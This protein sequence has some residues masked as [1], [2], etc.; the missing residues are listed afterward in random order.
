[1]NV[2]LPTDKPFE[3]HLWEPFLLNLDDYSFEVRIDILNTFLS[4]FPFTARYWKKLIFLHWQNNDIPQVEELFSTALPKCPDLDL[5]RFHIMFLSRDSDTAPSSEDASD[6]IDFDKMNDDRFER[7]QRGFDN[8]IKVLG[9]DY[10]AFPLYKGY[11]A[12]LD[13]RVYSNAYA[14]EQKLILLR[15]VYRQ[16]LRTPLRGGEELFD[17]Y[18]AF[19]KIQSPLKVNDL[20]NEAK[21]ELQTS[22]TV[23]KDVEAVRIHTDL[24]W[25]SLPPG[26]NGTE[27]QFFAWMR[28]LDF[29]L[30]NPL[31]DD[32][33][34]EKRVSLVLSQMLM[35]IGR[36]TEAWTKAAYYKYSRQDLVGASNVFRAGQQ[37]LGDSLLYILAWT[38]FLELI[39]SIDEALIVFNEFVGKKPSTL[40][41]VQYLRF[42]WRTRGVSEARIAFSK[43]LKDD[44]A[45]DYHL[46][47]EFA[48]LE[49][50][51]NNDDVVAQKIY[52]RGLKL[53]MNEPTYVLAYAE[54]L[55][56]IKDERNARVLFERVLSKYPSSQVY[57]SYVR[58]ELM[59]GHLQRVRLI[60]EKQQAQML[61]NRINLVHSELGS[62]LFNLIKRTREGLFWP[63]S[64]AEVS[65]LQKSSDETSSSF[66][67][68]VSRFYGVNDKGESVVSIQPNSKFSQPIKSELTMDVIEPPSMPVSVFKTL[69]LF[70][71]ES[72]NLN[73][74]L[75][76]DLL[77]RA[78]LPQVRRSTLGFVVSTVDER[79]FSQKAS[80]KRRSGSKV[81]IFVERMRKKKART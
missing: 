28:V 73:L 70:P 30:G 12:L 31:N 38:E 63:A 72:C 80:L 76:L 36:H 21:L 24:S 75:V 81:D 6:I 11:I 45:V 33:R 57:S 50:Q 59:F 35:Y 69:S 41:F 34:K 52:E 3:T 29:E 49:S 1:M 61:S 47:M 79:R 4:F 15:N 2:N 51:V 27:K 67:S 71:N 7:L 55:I 20:I 43:I 40:L 46:Y 58:F 9:E 37:L 65:L 14:E 23:L 74:E 10:A 22:K 68:E 78:D 53:F 25:L 60:E 17:L 39:G 66:R 5:Y 48:R 19:E 13:S 42:V 62:P 18:S 56:R 54:F 44:K 8:A 77:V 16:A 32:A 64:T 26:Y